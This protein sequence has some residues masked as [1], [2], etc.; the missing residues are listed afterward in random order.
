MGK[1]QFRALTLVCLTVVLV[2]GC[3]TSAP[4]GPPSL[5]VQYESASSDLKVILHPGLTD[6]DTLHVRVRN[7]DPGVLDG[8]AM[9]GWDSAH[10][11]AA[12]AGPR[13]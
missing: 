11:G 1:T 2:L 8:A 12:R 7:G 6:G 9:A 3:A 4:P 10:R 13:G 5:E